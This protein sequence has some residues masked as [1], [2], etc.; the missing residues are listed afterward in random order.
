MVRTLHIRSRL[1]RAG[2]ILCLVLAVQAPAFSAGDRALAEQ[3]RLRLEAQRADVSVTAAG[4]ELQ[5]A[6]AVQEFYARRV[7]EPVWFGD[8][9]LLETADIVPPLLASA[10]DD[11][12]QPEIYSYSSLKEAVAAFRRESPTV[13][14]VDLELAL[15]DSVLAYASDMLRGRVRPEDLYPFWESAPREL[16]LAQYLEQAVE[17]GKILVSLQDLAPSHP[18]Y[19]RLRTLLAWYRQIQSQGGPLPV[20]KGETLKPVMRS[21]RVAALRRRLAQSGD[22][23]A[24]ADDTEAPDLFDPTLEAALKR[25]QARHGLEADGV[26][27]AATLDTLAIPVAS[28]IRTIELNMERWRWLPKD[29]GD[30]YITVNIAGFQLNVVE[31][32]EVRLSMPVVVGKRYHETPVFSA[33]MTYIVFNPYWQVPPSIAVKEIL[34]KLK[35]D[36]SYLARESIKVFRGWEQPV[37]AINPATIDWSRVSVGS[38]P[39]RFRQEP[40]AQNALGR[41]KFMFPNKYNVYL[42]DTPAKE[43]FSRTTRS[44]SHGCIRVSRPAALADYLLRDKDGWD[45]QRIAAIEAGGSEQT[46]RLTRPWLVHILYWTA[47][48]DAAGDV[49]FRPDVY[50]RDERLARALYK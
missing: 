45:S 25:Y 18:A 40:G 49:Q 20:P 26:A 31:N 43:L 44:F 16:D 30:H 24:P 13:A 50:G 14:P 41:I 1:G 28:W 17:D 38:F 8:G 3:L 39:Y 47:W 15:T 33:P 32:D 6:T 37:S 23:A 7:Y 4:R 21:D 29:L 46:V 48:V 12:L 35:V 10:R 27:G 36:P 9:R 34:P 2:A 5:A 11:G 42:H 19:A 22:L